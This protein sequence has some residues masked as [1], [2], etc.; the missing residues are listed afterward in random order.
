MTFRDLIGQRHAR[1]LLQGALQSGRIAHAYLFV[2]PSGVGRLTAARAFAR[3]LL[4]SSGGDDACD[5]CSACRRVSAGVH[6]DLQVVAPGRGEAGAERRAVGIDQIRDLK[7]DASYPPYE[8]RW[9]VFIIESAEAMRAEA[10]NSLLKVLEEPPPGVVIVL[11]AESTAAVLPTLVSRSQVVRFSFVP[12]AEIARSLQARAGVPPERARYLAALAGG[13]AGAALAAAAAGDEV[14]ARRKEVVDTLAA[15]HAGGIVAQLGAAEALA[16]SREEI[17]RWLDIALVW[18]RDVVVW[19]ETQD[20]VL[21]VNL[22]LR[23]TVAEWAGRVPGDRLRRAAD[24]IEE[25]KAD[26]RRNLNPRLVLEALF[27]RMPEGAGR[28]PAGRT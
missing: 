6:P 1:A 3:A 2:G 25:A 11:I 23:D 5:R 20:P 14:V 8:A 24:A 26:L 9:K 13:R 17:E 16:R 21:L 4:C 12:A 22:D 28:A 10:A 18:V 7:R 19:Q 27:A 15:V